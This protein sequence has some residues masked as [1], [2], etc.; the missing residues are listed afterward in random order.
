MCS[1]HSLREE[2]EPRRV[3]GTRTRRGIMTKLTP[4][5]KT[6]NN[7]IVFGTADFVV[8][9]NNK[10]D[11]YSSLPPNRALVSRCTIASSFSD[12]DKPRKQHLLT[13]C[14]GFPAHDSDNIVDED[15]NPKV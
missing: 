15:W 5:K 11:A 9:L 12:E 14:T 2:E 6:N 10:H 8:C 1:G 7:L 4:K 13:S 3:L